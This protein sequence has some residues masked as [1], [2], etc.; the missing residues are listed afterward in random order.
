MNLISTVGIC[1]K[2]FA[3]ASF[4]SK[5]PLYIDSLFQKNQFGYAQK[6]CSH[7]TPNRTHSICELKS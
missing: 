6:Q 1:F 5:L 2:C 4:E 7:F 3:K